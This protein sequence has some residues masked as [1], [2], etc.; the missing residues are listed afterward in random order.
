MSLPDAERSFFA[1]AMATLPP[2]VSEYVAA[3]AGGRDPTGEHAWDRVRVVPRVWS[4]TT[5]VDLS[6]RVL[7]A[8]VASPVLV[9]PMAQ[10]VAAHE[11]GEVEM[12]RA[13]TGRGG[14]VGVS[15]NTAIPLARMAA[16]GVPWWFQVYPFAVRAV[17]QALVERAAAAGAS[18]LILTVDTTALSGSSM[19]EPTAW[20]PG[21]GS[22]RLANLT[23]EEK[24]SV[25]MLPPAAATPEDISWLRG[26]SGGLPVV[27]KGVLH[28]SDARIAADAG[29]SA[30]LVSTHGGRRSSLSVPTPEALPRVASEL[31]GSDVEVYADSGIRTGDHVL[32]ALTLGARAVFVGRPMWWALAAAGAR[33][34]ASELDRFDRELAIALRQAGVAAPADAARSR[35]G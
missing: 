24:E 28:P 6:T 7:G 18:A 4:E 32:A 35:A 14:I 17:T 3:T 1:R 2:H 23:P 30:V 19:V 26:I 29:A 15:T 34:V 33:G 13:L 16:L 22:R 11:D 20:P 5:S 27:V 8:R 31:A 21:P 12:T 10:Q 9:A 25:A